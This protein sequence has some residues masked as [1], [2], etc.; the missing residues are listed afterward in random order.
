[1]LEREIKVPGVY[2]HF[3]GDL[4]QVITIGYDSETM[5]EVVI[6]THNNK[7][8]VRDKEMFLSL[9]DHNKYPDI[10]QKYRFELVEDY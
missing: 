6:Y 4:C 3:K 7:V 1:M 8:W 9:V 5:K 2:R 10:K